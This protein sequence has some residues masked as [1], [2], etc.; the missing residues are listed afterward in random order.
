MMRKQEW[1]QNPQETARKFQLKTPKP[2][3]CLGGPHRDR[4]R[5]PPIIR[6]ATKYRNSVIPAKAGIHK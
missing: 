5:D 2:S 3:R 6:Q 4:T 1:G